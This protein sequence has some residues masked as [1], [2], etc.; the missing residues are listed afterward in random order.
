MPEKGHYLAII[1]AGTTGA[2]SVIFDPQGNLKAM[3]YKEYPEKR[4]P[5][6]VS[7]QD[8]PMWWSSSASTMKEVLKKASISPKEIAALSVST[9]RA[10][11]IAVDKDGNHLLPGITWMD[12]RT[13]PLIEPL[14]KK[15]TR[16]TGWWTNSSLSK[17]LWIKENHPGI[18][19]KTYKFIQVDAYLYHKLTGKIVTDYSNAIYG[20]IDTNTMSWSQELADAAGVPID[21]W[22]DIHAPGTPLGEVTSRAAE[23]TGLIAGLPVIMGGADVQCSALG[24][25]MTGPGP[26]KATTG[27][28]TFVVTVLEGKP[29]FDPGGNLFTNP[30]VIKDKWIL[31]G[32]LPGTGLLLK[33]FKDQFSTYE[34]NKAKESKIDPYDFLVEEAKSIDACAGGLLIVPLFTFAKGA[35]HGLSFGH[36]RKHIAR[37]ILECNAFAIRFYLTL[38][39]TMKMK[40]SEIRVDGGGSKSNLWN[41]IICDVNG[42]TVVVPKV[43]EGSSLGAAILAATGASI[44]KSVDEAIKNMVH[45]VDKKEP[46]REC[47]KA[48]NKM[49]TTFQN[50][51]M[52]TYLGKRVTGEITL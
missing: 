22:P 49:Y 51:L 43:T 36:T 10:T 3:S 21:K 35:I 50:L 18:F 24:L 25:G 12:S 17:I 32:A 16:P 20:I 41:Q 8:P 34:V 15:I 19:E 26:A 48:Y 31:E 47:L 6:G 11:T 29:I 33:W 52:T 23:E 37:A 46:D 45:F 4:Q 44:Y 2:R 7:E 5:P 38:M 28:G 14:K 39:E 30:Y 9:Q 42:K 1:D 27:T 13:S 40:S